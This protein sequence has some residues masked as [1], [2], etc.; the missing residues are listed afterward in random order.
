MYNDVKDLIDSQ[1][2]FAEVM[3]EAETIKATIGVV[4]PRG[5]N[6]FDGALS[7]TS[8][9]KVVLIGPEKLIRWAAKENNVNIDVPNIS[10][11]DVDVNLDGITWSVI[12]KIKDMTNAD[13][14]MELAASKIAHDLAINGDINVIMKGS[15]T[16]P[17]FL[18]GLVSK[19]MMAKGR[20]VSHVFF[21]GCD[22]GV[23]VFTDV[24]VNNGYLNGKLRFKIIENAVDAK[25]VL[26]PKKGDLQIAYLNEKDLSNHEDMYTKEQATEEIQKLNIKYGFNAD[27]DEEN[28]NDLL[29]FSK[30]LVDELTISNEEYL[31][32]HLQALHYLNAQDGINVKFDKYDFSI[33]DNAYDIFNFSDMDSGNK[34]YHSFRYY[35]QQFLNL[36]MRGN[37]INPGLIIGFNV[38]VVLTSRQDDATNRDMSIAIALVYHARKNKS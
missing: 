10:I 20:R 27:Y 36:G 2:C 35:N 17:S 7:A 22:N 18:K 12:D 6:A 3:A 14:A 31:Q 24:A 25:Q 11:H 5:K 33:D 30:E 28:D 32:D 15:L 19:K 34:V 9:G 8:R 4:H 23:S 1:G 38:P 37:L 16:S 26:F 21:K 13:H 29:D